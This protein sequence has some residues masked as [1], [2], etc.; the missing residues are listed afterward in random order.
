V[1]M[2]QNH[3]LTY[4]GGPLLF[5]GAYDCIHANSST[6]V[7]FVC[8]LLSLLFETRSRVAQADFECIG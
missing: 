2:V 4:R 6:S 8:V 3:L 7:F 5:P 1:L